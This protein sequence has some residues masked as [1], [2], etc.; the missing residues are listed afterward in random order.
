V[1]RTREPRQ[2][3]S[4]D[5]HVV[6]I[7]LDGFPARMLNDPDVPLPALRALAARGAVADGMRPVNPAVT[8]PNHTTFVTG[9]TAARHGVLFNGLLVRDRGGMPP[10]VEPWRDKREMVRVPT[11]YDLAH[12]R[13][14]TTAEVDWV[15]IQNPGTITWAF[16][17]RPDPQST[18]ARELVA[19][20]AISPD[21]LQAFD[22]HNVLWRDHIWT[23]AATHI[24]QRHHPNL[25]LFH[26]LNLDST[27]HRYGPGSPPA[28]TAMALLDSQLARVVD[29]IDR[30]GLRDRTTIIV[31]SD[32]GFRQVTRLI[33]PNTALRTAGL[34]KANSEG[35]TSCD[36]YVLAEGGTAFVYVTRPDASGDLLRR[37]RNSLEQLEGVDRVIDA[38]G[39]AALGLPSPADNEQMAALLL[40]AKDGYGFGG[41]ADGEPVVETSD[42]LGQ[43]GYLASDP[44]MNAIFVA[45]GRGIA[46]GTKMGTIDNVDVAPTIAALLG[47][48]LGPVDGRPLAQVLEATTNR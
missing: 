43:H 13:G 6:V 15:A 31:V 19:A 8:W 10:H 5:S 25:L 40:T 29:A 32:H 45:A 35:I 2:L 37:V 7:S 47:L 42:R 48:D 23:S 36:A 9:V 28:M 14:L 20:G 18:I 33:Q 38:A 41:S 30:S 27:E 17:E 16:S 4:R 1:A 21:D 11:V 3:A 22:R 39:Y 26:L 34:L 24:L 46:R 44:Q 12:A